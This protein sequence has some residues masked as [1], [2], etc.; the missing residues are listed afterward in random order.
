MET[1][2]RP[3]P[4]RDKLLADRDACQLLLLDIRLEEESGLELAKTLREH[5]V[6]CSLIYV[7]S[8][9]DYVFQSF[10]THPLH[11]LVKPIDREWL[12]GALRYDY[13]RRYR[14]ARVFLKCGGRQTAI[15]LEDIY[16]LEAAQHKV[17]VWLEGRYEMW[18]GTLSAL[19]EQLPTYCFCRCH[20]GFILNLSH[21]R[22]LVR[23]EARMDNGS[24]VPVSK[25]L[26]PEVLRRHIACLGQP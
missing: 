23:Y 3:E 11:Y 5:Q 13:R 9:Q 22:E 24:A 18:S 16:A 25:R 8:Y 2:S 15:R 26:Y 4:L 10:E 12:A 14:D 1:F 7:T 21:V 6:D 19:E 20:S 17:R